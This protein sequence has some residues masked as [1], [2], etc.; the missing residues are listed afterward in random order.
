MKLNSI[1]SSIF[2]VCLTIGF[3]GCK[4]GLDDYI[5]PAIQPHTDSGN[6]NPDDN[7]DFNNLGITP[8]QDGTPYDT[9]KGLIMCGYQGWFGTPD[10]GSLLTK[11]ERC[12]YHYQEHGQFRPGVMKNSIDFW[13]D[14]SEYEKQYTVGE[15]VPNANSSPFILPNGKKAT[16]FSPYDKSSVLLHFNWMK[17]YGIDGVFMQRFVGEISGATHKEHFDKVLDNAME[18]S[19]TYQRAIS[20]MYD[21]SGAKE[22]GW[23]LMVKD[24]QELMDKYALKDRTRQRFYLYQNGKPL[25]A[26]WGIGF[27]DTSHPTATKI[28]PYVDQLKQQGWSIMLGCPA[29]WR[30][31][32]NDCV[33]GTEHTALI[34]LIKECDA[35][36]PWYVGRYDYSNFSGTD[37]QNRIRLDISTAKTYANVV[38]ATHVYPGGSDR[39]MH[40]N[41]GLDVENTDNTG[42]RYGGKFYWQQF[43]QDIKNGVEAIY[44]GMFDEMDEGTAIFKQL[45][46]KDVPSNI[47]DGPDY[48]VTYKRGGSYDISTDVKTGDNV[49]W[50]R[51][52]TSLKVNF[53]GIDNNLPTD[54]YLWLTGQAAKMLNGQI[55]MTETIPDR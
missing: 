53:Q 20:V 7:T 21:L 43:Y 42:G 5:P 18:G 45:N 32:G 4:N 36:I 49:I 12:Y 8:H 26:L 46:T 38:Y 19:N 17:Q 40:P 39:N 13:P 35:F 14:M 1:C 11:Q 41:N 3:V 47:Y 34:N 9:F 10:D 30:M 50:S 27:N 24:A 28:K 33:S 54:H 44:V 51:L 29:Y 48:Y 16:V 55:R 22:E 23:K 37:W 15:E 31:G 52:A 2:L 6:G 25:L